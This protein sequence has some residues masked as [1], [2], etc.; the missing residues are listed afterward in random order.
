MRAV[1][2]GV[3][4]LAVAGGAGWYLVQP[5]LTEMDFAVKAELTAGGT[6]VTDDVAWR[7]L[8]ID[9]SVM[10]DGVQ[11]SASGDL[12]PLP[13]QPNV[14][15]VISGQPITIMP[16][17]Q[18]MDDFSTDV[19]PQ[20]GAVESHTVVFDS[21]MLALTVLT[22]TEGMGNLTAQSTRGGFGTNAQ[23]DGSVIPLLLEEGSYDISIEHNGVVASAPV[24]ITLGAR[25]TL[26]LDLRQGDLTVGL[27]NWD[28]DLPGGL[29]TLTT[30]DGRY[31][32]E[33]ALGPDGRAT[34]ADVLYGDYLVTIDNDG[35]YERDGSLQVTMDANPTEALLDWPFMR[36]DVDLSAFD[37]AADARAEVQIIEAAD[38]GIPYA[39]DIDV[40]DG[41]GMLAFAPLDQDPADL[42]FAISLR[43][44][45][46]VVALQPIGPADVGQSISRKLVPGEGYD[47]C[48]W[49]YGQS[50]CLAPQN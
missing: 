41:Q 5:G 22:E 40:S 36:V 28:E 21:G 45:N 8:Q 11:V 50:S 49:L 16:L 23:L 42:E 10:S 24:D 34:F 44:G 19:T 18:T 31:L 7:L 14:F 25:S 4:G 2:I 17:V 26:T 27:A 46:D 30:A 38:R 9:G 35:I 6:D 48:S 32:A 39:S 37:L 29:A 33:S 47:L 43:V 12:Q 20:L 13:D 15:R 3:L 1:I